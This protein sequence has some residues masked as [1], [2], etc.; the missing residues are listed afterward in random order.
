MN[1]SETEMDTILE[2]LETRLLVLGETAKAVNCEQTRQSLAEKRTRA[3][4]L[5]VKLQ[6][7]K[8]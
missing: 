3:Q 4:L 7:H 8:L 1:L 6:E 5:Y 2:A